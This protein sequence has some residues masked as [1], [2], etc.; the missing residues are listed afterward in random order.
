VTAL[1]VIWSSV[2]ILRLAPTDAAEGQN[3]EVSDATEPLALI[4]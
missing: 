3:A 2:L 4:R 1:L